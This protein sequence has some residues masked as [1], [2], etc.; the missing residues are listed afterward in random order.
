MMRLVEDD[1]SPFN[2]VRLDSFATVNN[3]PLVLVDDQTGEV[4][5]I[6]KSGEMRTITLGLH[7]IRIVSKR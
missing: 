4:A 7:S 3:G 5:W 6:D 2:A 1:A